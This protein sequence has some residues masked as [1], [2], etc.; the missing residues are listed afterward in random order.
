ME[1]VFWY[2]LFT[3]M[4]WGFAP[5]FGKLGLKMVD[6]LLA[7]GIRTFF[8]FLIVNFLVI[9]TGKAK[10]LFT[11]LLSRGAFYVS[12]EALFGAIL[13]QLF[14]FYALKEGEASKVVPIASTFPLF[15]AF[16]AFLFL[17]E[18]FQWQRL[19]GAAFIV[20]GMILLRILL[21]R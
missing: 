7:L 5:L 6:P 18:K 20:S 13:G 15:T 4:L 16:F 10:E 11:L 1:K 8:V 12:C 3:A 17:G 19:L 9:F 14:Y 2:A 21:R